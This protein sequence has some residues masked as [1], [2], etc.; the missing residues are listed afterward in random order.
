MTVP[1]LQLEQ[2]SFYYGHRLVLDNISLTVNAGDF[3]GIVGPNGSGKSTLLK[4]I[5]GLLRPTTG[6]VC[7][8]GCELDRYKQWTR[9]GYVSQQATAFNHGFPATVGEVVLS[10]LTASLGLFRR[11]GL[12]ERQR[13]ESALEKTGVLD[14]KDRIVGELSGGQQQ[15]VFIARALVAGPDLLILDE[16][17]VGVDA[18]AQEQFYELLAS[19]RQESG[20]TLL[21]VSHDIGVVTEHVGSV[22]CLNKKLHFHGSPADFW[23]EDTLTQVYGPAARVLHHA[24]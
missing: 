8:F 9:V 17:T 14:L 11:P 19:L 4:I 10:G 22:A 15:R 5:L 24:H 20:M 16:P 18:K 23:S 13:V 3:L 7:L 12:K 6:R 1:V 2:V 21:M